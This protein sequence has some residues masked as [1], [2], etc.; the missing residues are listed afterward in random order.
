MANYAEEALWDKLTPFLDPKSP[1]PY[2][3]AMN[4]DML[5]YDFE[6]DFSHAIDEAYGDSG[7]TCRLLLADF[8]WAARG[9]LLHDP[10][11]NTLNTRYPLFGSHVLTTLTMG[12]QSS[13]VKADEKVVTA[14]KNQ[15][16]AL[17]YNPFRAL[18]EAPRKAIQIFSP[19]RM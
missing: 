3:G 2:P 15:A 12:P 1:L 11:I 18:T 10:I 13:L 6:A 4:L 16:N 7:A 14:A 5:K 19:E 17:S 8:V 9:W